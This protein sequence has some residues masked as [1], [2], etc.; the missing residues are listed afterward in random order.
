MGKR[1]RQVAEARERRQAMHSVDEAPRVATPRS[2]GK[3][4]ALGALSALWA[5]VLW[6][7]LVLV[8]SGGSSFCGFGGKFDCDAVWSGALASTV[9]KLTGLP[10]AGWGLVWSAV[11]F[12]LPLVALTRI[13][14]GK[15]I[16]PLVSAVRLTGLAGILSVAVML[17]GS[18]IAGAVCIGCI[19]TYVLVGAYAFISLLQWRPA[20]FPSA[21]RGATLAAG[22]A[23]VFFLLL[24]YPGL[25]TPKTSGEAGRRAVAE[26]ARSERTDAGPRTSA[27]ARR[28]E[29]VSELVGSLE[30]ALRQTLA[31]SLAIYR[32]ST[33]Q[34]PPAPRALVGSDL[35]PVRI[36]EFT[37]I[38]CEHCAGLHETIKTLRESLPPGS[39]SVDSR[40]FPLD[41]RCNP[42]VTG[43][44]EDDVRCVAAKARICL[45]PSGNE[46]KL[47]EALFARQK[48]LTREKVFEIAAPFMPR[49]A[50]EACIAAPETAAKLAEDISAAS[51]YDS[52][53]TPIVVVNGRKGTSFGPF[54][55]TII[56]TRGDADHPALSVLPPGD[57]GAHLH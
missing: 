13:A 31:D 27:D 42:I 12:F 19:G 8:R 24:L 11:A 40:Q 16:D 28:D 41:S 53:G 17:A 2:L 49:P 55:Y 7:E 30:P 57:P 51:R 18:A 5:V 32:A 39:F 43:S 1:E 14:E 37:D 50:L 44:R 45:E 10:I 26:A 23:L 22:A 29:K 34:Q 20:G 21:R 15:R 4:V 9:H 56:Q 38:L 47:A 6:E 46:P 36:T 25:R 33:T 35:A 48:G 52:D 3:L 54:L